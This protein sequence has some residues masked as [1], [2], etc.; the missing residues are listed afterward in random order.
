VVGVGFVENF[1]YGFSN[2]F[3]DDRFDLLLVHTLTASMFRSMA[4]AETRRAFAGSY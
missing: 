2:S 4:S 1:F 3:L